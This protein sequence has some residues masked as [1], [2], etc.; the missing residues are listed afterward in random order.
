M[1]NVSSIKDCYG[2]GMCATVC[3]QRIIEIRLNDDGFYEPHITHPDKCTDCGLCTSVCAFFHNERSAELSPIGCYAA[4]SSNSE[5]RHKCSSGG[6]S[7]ELSRH[8]L[9]HGFKI[10]GVKYNPETNRAEHYI[11]KSAEELDASIGS[12]YIQSYTV[13]AFRAVNRNE[14]YLIIG[15]PCQIDSFRRYIRLFKKEENF[16]LMDFFCHG[17]PTMHLWDK[18]SQWVRQQIGEGEFSYVSWRNKA[19]GWHNSWVMNIGNAKGN[20]VISIATKG[21]M[22]YRM[23]LSDTCLGKQCYENCKYK[24]D[25]S[26]A[27]IRIGDMWGNKFRNNEAGV[28]AVISFT[29]IGEKLLNQT[30]TL[31]IEPYKF[32]TVAEGQMKTSPHYPSIKNNVMDKLKSDDCTLG[33]ACNIVLPY[34]QRQKIKRLLRHPLRTLINRLRKALK[35]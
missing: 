10:C 35:A 23:F 34:I 4:W 12:K 13:D 25:K 20:K 17:V 29:P 9:K 31:H 19:K 11:A 6:A 22:F 1:K 15:T 26:A 7:Y 2:C 3:G 32:T 8:L 28:N 27:D 30:E 21:D 5:I 33:D 16:I 18:Y 14:K 24:Y